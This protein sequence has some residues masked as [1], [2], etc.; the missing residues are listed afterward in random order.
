MSRWARKCQLYPKSSSVCVYATVSVSGNVACLSW[1]NHTPRGSEALSWTLYLTTHL[2]CHYLM[3]TILPVKPYCLIR[4]YEGDKTKRSQMNRTEDEWYL[5]Q[6][7]AGG[8]S[9]HEQTQPVTYTFFLEKFVNNKWGETQSAFTDYLNC[10]CHEMW[11][12]RSI[13]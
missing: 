8:W 13:I 2:G 1:D 9:H 3:I 10:I 6:L 5:N 4:G 7:K 12:W 11:C